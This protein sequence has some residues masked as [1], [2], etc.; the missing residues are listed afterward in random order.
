MSAAHD[1]LSV[2][3]HWPAKQLKVEATEHLS[4]LGSHARPHQPVRPESRRSHGLRPPGAEPTAANH[5]LG[6]QLVSPQTSSTFSASGRSTT[7]A[8]CEKRP[9]TTDSARQPSAPFPRQTTPIKDACS[10]QRAVDQRAVQQACR[11]EENR[12]RNEGRMSDQHLGPHI[13]S[14]C[15]LGHNRANDN[16]D[17]RTDAGGRT[18]HRRSGSEQH[19]TSCRTIRRL[20]VQCTSQ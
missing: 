20:S 4:R 10:R 19:L 15:E 9:S 11:G 3:R 2:H 5:P 16:V 12:N 14:G 8:A 6:D 18:S 7:A 17:R 13:R 1:Q